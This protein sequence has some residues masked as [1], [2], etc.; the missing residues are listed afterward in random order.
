MPPLL[1]RLLAERLRETDTGCVHLIGRRGKPTDQIRIGGRKLAPHLLIWELLNG[2]IP[3]R[4]VLRR[5]CAEPRCVNPA[6]F[7][8]ATVGEIVTRSSSASALNK[9]KTHCPRGHAYNKANTYLVADGSRRCRACQRERGSE[10]RRL[11][12]VAP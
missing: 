8:R 12:R 4:Y 11:R 5:L 9:L 7:E 3:S 6:H 10:R 2:A 1:E